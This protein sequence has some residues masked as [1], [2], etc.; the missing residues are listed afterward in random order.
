MS[1][2]R[3]GLLVREYTRTSACLHAGIITTVLLKRSLPGSD[4]GPGGER[5]KKGS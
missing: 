4:I 1:L 5:P 3:R 2:I